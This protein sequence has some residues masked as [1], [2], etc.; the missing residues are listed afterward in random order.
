MNFLTCIQTTFAPSDYVKPKKNVQTIC[1]L[2]SMANRL[3]CNHAGVSDLMDSHAGRLFCLHDLCRTP[4]HS[5]IPRPFAIIHLAVPKMTRTLPFI[6]K[7]KGPLTLQ[8]Y[9]HSHQNPLYPSKHPQRLALRPRPKTTSL[10]P[11]LTRD[12]HRS[13]SEQFTDTPA[14]KTASLQPTPLVRD[15]HSSSSETRPRTHWPQNLF[16]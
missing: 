10:Q 12:P 4:I 13:S 5:I 6:H 7:L 8:I 11:T 3:A 1:V 16:P 14:A 9:V 2:R 15:P